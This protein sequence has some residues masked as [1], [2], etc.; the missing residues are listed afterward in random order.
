M[1][2]KDFF[3]NRGCIPPLWGSGIYRSIQFTGFEATF[4]LNKIS[5]AQFG[6]F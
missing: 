5:L 6:G 3:F 2:K 1:N 4:V